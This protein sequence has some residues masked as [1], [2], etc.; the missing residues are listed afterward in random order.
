MSLRVSPSLKYCVSVLCVVE[1][2]VVS[3]SAYVIVHCIVSRLAKSAVSASPGLSAAW[4]A[5]DVGELV[6]EFVVCV[7]AASS[8]TRTQSIA[9]TVFIGDTP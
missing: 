1:E 2:F 8:K 4:L 9:T 7:H 5:V 6:V 3:C